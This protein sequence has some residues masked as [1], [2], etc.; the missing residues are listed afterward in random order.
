L[1]V[2]KMFEAVIWGIYACVFIGVICIACAIV[3][4]VEAKKNK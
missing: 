1:E 2:R 4:R 3:D